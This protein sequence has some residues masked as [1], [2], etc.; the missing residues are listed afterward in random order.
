MVFAHRHSEWLD[1]LYGVNPEQVPAAP[2]KN[3]AASSFLFTS[4]NAHDKSSHYVTHGDYFNSCKRDYTISREE[5]HAELR[6]KLSG[7]GGLSPTSGTT[8]TS[9]SV[10]VL[11]LT[12]AY[13]APPFLRATTGSQNE[14]EDDEEVED[15]ND[16]AP[17]NR[18]RTTMRD[19][20][21]TVLFGLGVVDAASLALLGTTAPRPCDAALRTWLAGS[22]LCGFPVSYIVAKVATGSPMDYFLPP[23]GGSRRS[24]WSYTRFRLRITGV[25]G[26][27]TS[28]KVHF[29]FFLRDSHGWTHS[30]RVIASAV[31]DRGRTHEIAFD[32]PLPFDRYF[33]CV[34]RRSGSPASANAGHSDD[35]DHRGHD[36]TAIPISWRLEGC[37]TK[38]QTTANTSSRNAAS[39]SQWVLLDEQQNAGE[40]FAELSTSQPGVLPYEAS[41]RRTVTT[42]DFVF[43]RQRAANFRHAF[44]VETAASIGS[45]LWLTYGSTLLASSK[46]G[47]CATSLVRKYAFAQVAAT[48]GLISAS[49]LFL[50]MTSVAAVMLQANQATDR[51]QTKKQ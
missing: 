35:V 40:K 14:V 23:A 49:S 44:A 37:R 48:W 45:F 12:N 43:N 13:R 21:P 39:F 38:K 18:P 10:S 26:G 19:W 27:D 9:N 7:V 4:R 16:G 17:S 28:K 29:E 3:R 33:L 32:R 8:G 1:F 20:L 36:Q 15:D 22:V 11:A 30:D 46:L 42:E 2:G 47:P 6:I 31:R 41:K 34:G 51:E 50:I 5:P 25:A 24:G